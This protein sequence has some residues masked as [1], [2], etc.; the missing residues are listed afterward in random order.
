MFDIIFIIC[1]IA[2]A[3]A[4]LLYSRSS[5]GSGGLIASGTRETVVYT[6]ELQGMLGD[7]A[8]L[9]QAG[10]SLVDKVEKRPLGTVVSVKVKPGLTTQKNL[11]TGDHIV[12]QYPD[13]HDAE[14]VVTADATETESQISI[15]GGFVVRVGTWVSLNG[16]LYSGVGYIVDMERDDVS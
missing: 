14:I 9:I 15:P 2:I 13:R 5:G 1:A 10:D 4:I 3:G 8:Y 6:I 12:T 7:S 11:L 16:P